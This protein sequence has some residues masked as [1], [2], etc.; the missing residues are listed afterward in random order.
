MFAVG[1]FDSSFASSSAL[2]Q[3]AKVTLNDVGWTYDGSYVSTDR[4]TFAAPR[5]S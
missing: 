2:G 3:Q 1:R 4:P 5:A